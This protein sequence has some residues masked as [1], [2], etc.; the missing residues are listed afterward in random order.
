MRRY[1]SL[2]AFAGLLM[3]ASG[4][5]ATPPSN[6]FIGVFGDPA[7]TNCCINM[8]PSGN[9]FLYVFA[10]TGGAA[11]AGITGAEFRVSVEPAVPGANF[12]W[13]PA[14]GVVSSGSP[15]D[16]GA[17]GG[18]SLSFQSCQTQTGT[19]GDKV[20]LG[21]IHTTGLTGQHQLVVRRHSTPNPN[22]ACPCV[23]DCG[24]PASRVCLTL[25]QGDPELLGQEPAAFTSTINDPSCAGASCGYVAIEASTWTTMKN[26][27]R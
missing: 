13:N 14:N 8:N 17:G 24:G 5:M 10:V 3:L 12:N 22:F 25:Q 16:N 7:G 23:M 2:A 21:T 4:V 26:L 9:G 1:S 27:F 6:G 19:A 18:I 15:V 11:S 20:L